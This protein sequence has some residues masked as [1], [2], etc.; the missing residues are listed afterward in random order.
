MNP[1]VTEAEFQAMLERA[2]LS[3]SERAGL[4]LGTVQGNVFDSYWKV[5]GSTEA[6]AYEPMLK[7]D[8]L[9]LRRLLHPAASTTQGVHESEK[10]V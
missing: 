1:A 4:T 10:R 6:D 5:N 8:V 3:P 9:D 2:E 7:V